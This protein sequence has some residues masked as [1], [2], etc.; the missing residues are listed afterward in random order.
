MYLK[1]N[2]NMKDKTFPTLGSTEREWAEGGGQRHQKEPA[3][4]QHLPDRHV[5]GN[6][7]DTAIQR[8]VTSRLPDL[9][10]EFVG[11]WG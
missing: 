11:N 10:H 6:R 8:A 1:D 5:L 4:L 2:K 3:Q 7:L 9:Y